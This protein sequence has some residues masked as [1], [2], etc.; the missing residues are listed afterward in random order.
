MGN[1]KS[2]KNYKESE[3]V[4]RKGKKVYQERKLQDQDAIKQIKEYARN[5]RRVPDDN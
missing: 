3:A 2:K 5:N 4:T 1:T